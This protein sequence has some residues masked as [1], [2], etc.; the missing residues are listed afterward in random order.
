MFFYLYFFIFSINLFYCPQGFLE[1]FQETSS[2][3]NSSA[4]H[5][6]PRNLEVA[7]HKFSYKIYFVAIILFFYQKSFEKDKKKIWKKISSLV[8]ISEKV[9]KSSFDN[10]FLN[11]GFEAAKWK[12]RICMVRI[13]WLKFRRT[14][15]IRR[16]LGLN[17]IRKLICSFVFSLKGDF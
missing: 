15:I 5:F 16:I 4:F 14:V 8:V 3:E 13:F 9:H 6:I 10:I 1:N 17:L 2:V 7:L 12:A 11:G